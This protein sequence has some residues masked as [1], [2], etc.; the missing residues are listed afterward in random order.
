MASPPIT[1]PRRSFDIPKPEDGLAEWTSKIRALQQQVDA[2]EEA[3]HRRLEEEIAASRL[4]RMRR[5]RGVGYDS[6]S[7]TSSVELDRDKLSNLKED[8]DTTTTDDLK[9]IAERQ[10]GQQ[11]AMRKLMGSSSPPAS[12]SGS[13]RVAHSVGSGRPEPMSLAAFMGG[14]ATGPR[15]NK[16]APQQDAHDPRQFEQ[17]T[18]IT[19]P[20]PVFGRGGIAMP[21]MTKPGKVQSSYGRDSPSGTS[22]GMG[23]KKSYPDLRSPEEQFSPRERNDSAPSIYQHSPPSPVT[24]RPNSVASR[25]MDAITERPV[26]PQKTGGRSRERTMSTPYRPPTDRGPF[27]SSSANASRTSLVDDPRP[28]SPQKTGSRERRLSTP[29]RSSPTK[30]VSFVLPSDSESSEVP[31]SKRTSLGNTSRPKTPTKEPSVSKSPPYKPVVETPYLARTIQPQP[32]SPSNSPQISA[33][34]TPSP[35][36]L[37]PPA[38]KEPTPSLSRL[39]GRGFV[40][41][42]VKVTQQLEN[43]SPSTSSQTTPEKLGR[44]PAVLDRWQPRESSSPSPA[45]PPTSPR[46]AVM[47]KSWT[48]ETAP[49]EP[50]PTTPSRPLRSATSFTSFKQNA[51]KNTVQPLEKETSNLPTQELKGLGSAT[52]LVVFKPAP[53]EDATEFAEVDELGRKPRTASGLGGNFPAQ[54]GKP[55]I[56]PTRE[57]AKKPKKSSTARAVSKS[58]DGGK[59]SQVPLSTARSESP[60]PLQAESPKHEHE[61]DPVVEKKVSQPPKVTPPSSN[62]VRS[63]K[64]TDRWLDQPVIGVKPVLSRESSSQTEVP[65]VLGLVGRKPLPGLAVSPALPSTLINRAPSK[66]PEIPTTDSNASSTSKSSEGSRPITPVRHTRIPSTGNRA[67][68]MDIAQAFD[69]ESAPSQKTESPVQQEE[70]PAVEVTPPSSPVVAETDWQPV[71]PASLERRRSTFEKFAVPSLPPLKEEATPTPSPAGTLARVEGSSIRQPLKDV[72]SKQDAEQAEPNTSVASPS[73]MPKGSKA[74]PSRE[75]SKIVHL[76]YVDQPLPTVDYNAILKSRNNATTLSKDSNIFHDSEVLAIVRRSKSK[77][78]GLVVT[79]VWGWFGKHSRHGE[80]ESQKLDELAKRYGTTMISVKQS[81]EPVDL[82]E[83]LGGQ[84]STRQGPRA[85]WS[86]EN[87]TMHMIRSRNGFIFIDELELFEN[88]LIISKSIKNLCSGFSYCLSILDTVYVWNGH[89][90]NDSE[91]RAASQYARSLTDNVVEL[92]QG[93]NDEEEMFWMV[94]GDG[95]FAAADYWRWKHDFSEYE[96][97]IWLVNANKP[98]EPVS[99]ILAV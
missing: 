86:P 51:D 66:S 1:S 39:A 42:M 29:G 75:G 65:K 43:R 92:T 78:S 83:A 45:S 62:G 14:R 37:K 26:S 4:A 98:G 79:T 84:V 93:V 80:R 74:A 76:S 50:R 97:K 59:E 3:E 40:Q 52:T 95:T 38:P 22:V 27:P 20:H 12:V 96:P 81:H 31:R 8:N 68:V 56:H 54:T 28:V 58:E 6:G 24:L 21:G 25:Y 87:T 72:F 15:L 91:R 18:H 47:R 23:R 77:S 41:N 61:S 53:V 63:G 44:K 69:Q 36:F 73:E 46:P 70:A 49:S 35:A 64:V 90:S 48:T 9:S 13:E 57:R 2:D 99:T 33:S 10:R 89:G 94:L 5:S 85:H 34:P 67:T 60:A 30:G 7:R 19:S 32:R 82:V 55:L 71:S 17:R 88:Q 16:H 11:D